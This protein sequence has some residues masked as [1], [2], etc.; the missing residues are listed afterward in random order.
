M[1]AFIGVWPPTPKEW[2]EVKMP[3]WMSP[4]SSLLASSGTYQALTSNLEYIVASFWTTLNRATFGSQ[5]PREKNRFMRVQPPAKI[6]S[7]LNVV[8][9]CSLLSGTEKR[10]L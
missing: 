3:L 9:S 6:D 8:P 10:G 4:V 2:Q 1:V 5:S 7:F